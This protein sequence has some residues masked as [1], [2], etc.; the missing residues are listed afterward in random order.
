MV[1]TL[2]MTNDQAQEA[3]EKGLVEMN[4][5][6][7][8][9]NV[10]LENESEIKVDGKVVRPAKEFVYIRFHKPAGYEST[11]SKNVEN[12]LSEFFK[13]MKGLS[14]AGRLD[15]ASE[16]LLLLSNDGKWVENITNPKFE[17]EKEYLVQLDKAPTDDFAKLFTSGVNIGYHVTKPCECVILEDNWIKVK[18][19]EGKNRQIRKMCK[20]LNYNVLTLKRIRIDKVELGSLK[21]GEFDFFKN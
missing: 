12:N 1:H 20:T 9:E 2:K 16:G 4:G 19:K 13:D 15:K 6:I 5:V 11:L 7:I 10:F 17:K 8:K 21:P 14:I 18:L 3:L